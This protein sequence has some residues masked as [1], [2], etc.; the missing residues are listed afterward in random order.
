[1]G[2]MDFFKTKQK[3]KATFFDETGSVFIKEVKYENN[4]FDVSEKL[5]GKKGTYIVDANFIVYARKTRTPMAYYYTNNPNP[6]HIQHVRN[7]DVDSIGFKRILDSKVIVDLF[8]SDGIKF[9]TVILI[10]CIII[11][12]ITAGLGWGEYK[13]IDT[14]GNLTVHCIP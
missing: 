5:F 9:L 10:L 3:L 8:S 14:M 11:L 13:T 6:I 2:M 12:L 7:K 1:M 4:K